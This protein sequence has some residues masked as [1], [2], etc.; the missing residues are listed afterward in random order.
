MRL[1]KKPE[2]NTDELQ[3][4]VEKAMG[5]RASVK[6]LVETAQVEIKDLDEL[7]RQSKLP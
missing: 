4:A 2:H 6:K 7:V 3:S 5:S 1:D